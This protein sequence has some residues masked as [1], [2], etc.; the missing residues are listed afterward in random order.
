MRN[1]TVSKK[2]TGATT[3]WDALAGNVRYHFEYTYK[4]N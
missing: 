4:T 2:E 1:Y 3:F